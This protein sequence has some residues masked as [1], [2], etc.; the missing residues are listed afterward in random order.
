MGEPF[1]SLQPPVRPSGE[2]LDSWKEIA[3]YLH[4]DIT[5]VQRWE[6]R[7]GMPVHRHVHDKR[8]SVYA[9]TFELDVWLQGR[10]LEENGEE[11]KE[12]EEAPAVATSDQTRRAARSARWLALGGLV[13]ASLLALAL[14]R[15]RRPAANAAPL[16]IRSLA[17]LPLEN[18]SGD[19]AQEYLADG[20]TDALIGRLSSI[21]DL[22]VISRT[23]V[24]RFKN[25][26]LSVPEIARILHVDAI[27]EGSVARDGDHIRVTAEL[28]RGATDGH[29][30]SQTYD[31]EQRDV[32][33]LQSELAQ[34]IADKV[35]VTVTGQEQKRLA[36]ARSVAPEVYESYLQGSYDLR[37]SPTRAT[38]E[39]SIRHF[40]D[41]IKRD[42]AFAQAYLGLATAYDN[43]GSTF[44]GE[45]SD[46]S[47]HQQ[48]A[49][50][51][52]AVELDP[53]LAGAHSLL[54]HV[55]LRQ[56]HWPE[57]ESEYKRALELNPN[58]ANAQIGLAWWLLFRG[59]VNEAL[60]LAQ[61]ARELDPL[62]ID[63]THIGWMLFEARRYS[64]SMRE[65]RAVLA[66]HPDD[67][68]T[69]WD[70]GIALIDENQA[71]EAIVVLEKAASLSHRSPGVMGTLI[72]AYGQSG[73]RSDALRLLGELQRSRKDG[74][75][76][77]GAFVNAYL[78]LGEKDQVFA[79]LNQAYQEHANSLRFLKIDPAYDSVRN[80]PR[81][82]EL[83]RRVGLA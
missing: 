73:R 69:L 65:L 12:S 11:G 64:D 60:A 10:R 58:D 13:A 38:I 18:L 70:M 42:P 59:R 6:K 9:V 33:S 4:R 20:M 44:I 25:P 29:F 81:F 53:E 32:L 48:I 79:W 3:A 28:I 5:T 78:G 24:M 74:F 36:A 22:R 37:K 67:A 34:A 16:K 41:A 51:Q 19:P 40:D 35:E 54:A 1:S 30:W 68:V 56:W 21:H 17:V 15:H 31:R 77:P 26:Q 61:Q 8:G 47:L 80:D 23:S 45:P 75:V 83:L 63:G 2:R 76:P 49:A 71:N 27:V 55:E 72:R 14:I 52:K 82:A 39:D 57:A 66:V 43:L 46:K 50:A 62:T 7:E